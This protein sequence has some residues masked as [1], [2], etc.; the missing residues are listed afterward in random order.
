MPYMSQTPEMPA[1]EQWLNSAHRRLRSIAIER[2]GKYIEGN[3]AL[4]WWFPVSTHTESSSI[5]PWCPLWI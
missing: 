1:G 4:V 5:Y 2:N 3:T